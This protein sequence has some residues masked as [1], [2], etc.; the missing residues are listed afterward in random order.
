MYYE[1][2]DAWGHDAG[3]GSDEV[4]ARIRELDQILLD[5]QVDLDQHDDINVVM[6]SDHGMSQR[7]SQNGLVD[8]MEYIDWQTIDKAYGS[9]AG[10][11]LQIWPEEGMNELVDPHCITPIDKGAII[12]L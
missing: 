12:T 7:V 1:Q 4:I 3:P 11:V 10:P 8:I 5:L 6:F 9:K 2:I